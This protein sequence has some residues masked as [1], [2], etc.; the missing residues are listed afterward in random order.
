MWPGVQGV[1]FHGRI[2]RRA[3]LDCAIT[4]STAQRLWMTELTALMAHCHAW[5]YASDWPSRSDRSNGCPGICRRSS[6]R[7]SA[8]QKVTGQRYSLLDIADLPNI[9]LDVPGRRVASCGAPG[10]CPPRT[11]PIDDRR[12]VFRCRLHAAMGVQRAC[13]RHDRC[14]ARRQAMGLCAN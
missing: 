8:I 14:L 5:E 9:T 4:V 1:L 2:V 10:C 3:A 7:D 6:W 13:R 11:V 12:I